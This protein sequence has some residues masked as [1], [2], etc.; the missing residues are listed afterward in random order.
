MKTT[1]SN[2]SRK[3]W[4]TL[5]IVQS[6]QTKC[7]LYEMFIRKPTCVNKQNYI[8]FRNKLSQSIRN[9]KQ[10]Y[11]SNL[12]T[13]SNIK[14][15]WSCINSIIYGDKIKHIPSQILINYKLMTN[16]KTFVYALAAYFAN[17]GT[18]LS[19]GIPSSTDPLN[20]VNF[21]NYSLFFSPTNQFE[22]E[23]I[24]YNFKITSPGYD[25]MHQEIIEKISMIIAMPLSHIANCSLISGI[26]PSKHIIAKVIP[27]FKN[28]LHE[29]MYDHRPISPLPCFS[30][31]CEKIIASR[32]LSF[33]LRHNILYDH[34]FGFMSGKNTTHAILSLV[35]YLINS[36][37]DNKLTCGIFLDISMTF[38]TIDHNILLSKLY[39]YGIGGNTLNRFMNYLSNL[40]QFVSINNTSSSFL[41]MECGVPQGS[42]LGPTFFLLCINDLPRVCTKLK[43]LLYADDTYILYENSDTKAIAKIINMEMPRNMEWLK[44]NK[45]HIDVNKSVA[46]LFHTRQRR[47]NTDENSIVID[48]NIIPFTTNA[49]FLGINID[50]NLTWKA[51]MNYIT[52]KISKGVGLLL[53]L[54]KEL[55]CVILILIYNTILL[56]YLTYCRIIWGFTYQTYINEILTIQKRQCT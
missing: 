18:N 46:M 6:C 34:Q 24:I 33:L 13:K 38:D 51:H 25:D 21:L 54:S 43:F 53:H 16:Y 39:K 4:C 5:D 22:I 56:S 40:Y 17:P 41:R 1:K 50:N 3:D 26:V 44:S 37:E 11:Y 8:T 36:F 12:F 20:Y 9:A 49:K 52:A 7:K 2:R 29:D 31:I 23:K 10:S 47:V 55:S 48:G 45:L 35:D 15:T 27:I 19:K 14:K 30:K 28:G 42:I 32:L